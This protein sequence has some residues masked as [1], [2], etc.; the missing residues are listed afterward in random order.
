MLLLNVWV[1]CLCM[2]LLMVVYLL[3]VRVLLRRRRVVVGSSRFCCVMFL[4]LLM[5]WVD[6][7]VW[8]GI[9]V[10]LRDGFCLY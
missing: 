5:L 6:V 3:S 8:G 10:L 9:F 7:L 4:V 2:S 1:D